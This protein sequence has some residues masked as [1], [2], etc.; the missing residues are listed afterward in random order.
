MKQ[1]KSTFRVKEVPS[2][3]ARFKT[4]REVIDYLLELNNHNIQKSWNTCFIFIIKDYYRFIIKVL[5]KSANHF[6]LYT[7]HPLFNKF[8]ILKKPFLF[9]VYIKSTKLAKKSSHIGPV[10]VRIRYSYLSHW[11]RLFHLLSTHHTNTFLFYCNW[12]RVPLID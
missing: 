7:I 2:H 10:F 9:F 3:L 6:S 12:T 8:R 4:W 5:R 11:V 1:S